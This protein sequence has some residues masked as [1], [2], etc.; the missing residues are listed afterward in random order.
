[1]EKNIMGTWKLIKF[2]MKTDDKISQPFGENPLGYLF[3][4]ENGRMA[5]LISKEN[6][7][8][9][10]TQDITNIPETE[11]SQLADG[12]IGYTGKYE[13]LDDKIIHHV[14]ISFIPNWMGRP[15]E[16]F[17][18]H[19]NG[20]LVLETPAE[21]IEGSKFISRLIWEKI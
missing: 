11:K 13:I 6:R 2:E 17:Y 19:H 3:Y 15:L 9:V 7:K 16:R 21:E 4:H 10:S 5:V 1:M 20:K 12:F 8:T 14:E 18:Q